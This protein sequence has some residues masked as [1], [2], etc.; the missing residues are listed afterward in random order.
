MLFH[1]TVVALDR[2]DPRLRE[3]SQ[4]PSGNRALPNYLSLGLKKSH[5]QMLFDQ[6]DC[7]HLVHFEAIKWQLCVDL[8][9]HDII[10]EVSF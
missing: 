2:S 9:A 10:F 5:H 7:E 3:F 4:V 6:P 8:Y 1:G